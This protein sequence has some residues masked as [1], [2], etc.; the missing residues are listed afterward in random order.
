VR[1]ADRDDLAVWIPTPP[2]TLPPG[3]ALTLTHRFAGEPAPMTARLRFTPRMRAGGGQVSLGYR[4]PLLDREALDVANLRATL[5]SRARELGV[6]GNTLPEWEGL[7]AREQ[8]LAARSEPH[9]P[10]RVR[11]HG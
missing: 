9:E 8:A 7:R 11:D 6:P 2:V 10:P 3:G 5:T 4:I 1:V